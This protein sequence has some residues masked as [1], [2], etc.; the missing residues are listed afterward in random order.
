MAVFTVW[1]P[2]M[3]VGGCMYSLVTEHDI[4]W[5]C[6]CM[7]T[8]VTIHDSWWHGGCMYSLATEH[9]I[10]CLYVQSGYST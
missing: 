7:Y 10:W 9:E 8:I 3:L 4:W 5:L 2:Y 1:L 6:G